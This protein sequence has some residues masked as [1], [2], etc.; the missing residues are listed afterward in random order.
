MASPCLALSAFAEVVIGTSKRRSKTMR[1]HPL[2]VVTSPERRSSETASFPADR[3]RM[4]ALRSRDLVRPREELLPRSQRAR[5][6]QGVDA[7]G[8]ADGEAPPTRR[9]AGR[10]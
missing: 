8:A 10:A 7:S 5:P 6:D 3:K 1:A 2:L 9:S 4:R